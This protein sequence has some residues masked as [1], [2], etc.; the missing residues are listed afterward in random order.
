MKNVFHNVIANKPKSADDPTA[1]S[2]SISVSPELAHAIITSLMTIA[3]AREFALAIE[4]AADEA[5]AQ[6]PK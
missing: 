5:E 2:V 6:L 3:A 4:R 1:V